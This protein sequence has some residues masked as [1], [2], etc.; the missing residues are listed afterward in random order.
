MEFFKSDLDCTHKHPNGALMNEV[1]PKES[2]QG[3]KGNRVFT[4][5]IISLA[6]AMIVWLAVE[7]YGQMQPTPGFMEDDAVPP[8]NPEQQ[9]P[10]S[11]TGAR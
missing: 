10:A 7:I 3:G 1:N 2:R 6:L 4:I 5:L 9:P 11:A 8:A